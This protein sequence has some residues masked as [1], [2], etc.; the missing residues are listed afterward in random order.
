[1]QD[2][3]SPE[4][5][6]KQAWLARQEETK[7]ARAPPPSVDTADTIA[8]R[9]RERE[10]NR[11]RMLEM[12]GGDGSDKL[13]RHAGTAFGFGGV[14]DEDYGQER[15]GEIDLMT[16]VPL[17]AMV[18]PGNG[19]DGR[20]EGWARKPAVT[21]PNPPP[22]ANTLRAPGQ[23]P[24]PAYPATPAEPAPPS[25]EE[26]QEVAPKEETSIMETMMDVEKRRRAAEE[27]E[28]LLA[29]LRSELK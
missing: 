24:P 3:L 12:M 23:V 8:A 2:S 21:N 26:A 9:Q 13:R 19:F 7:T 25:A 1:M 20:D 11:K 27:E 22:M 4:E 18:R 16:G 28:A 17:S 6:A 29:A 14:D 10:E 15:E 5:V